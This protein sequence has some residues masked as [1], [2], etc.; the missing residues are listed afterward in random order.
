MRAARVGQA[1]QATDLVEG[2]ASSVI[3]GAAQLDNVGGDITYQHNGGMSAR[4]DQADEALRQRVV[5]ELVDGQMPDD[6]V[7]A[8]DRHVQGHGQG[9]G[10]TDA[11][12][13]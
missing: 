3:E 1:E 12:G 8:V 10:S 11:H 13:Q 7:D 6:V 9:L 4:D 2:F 5:D